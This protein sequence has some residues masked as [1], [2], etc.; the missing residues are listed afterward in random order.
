MLPRLLSFVTRAMAVAQLP[1]LHTL[2]TKL[3]APPWEVPV[4]CFPP[5]V[6]SR[7]LTD[8]CRV[9]FASGAT[10]LGDDPFLEHSPDI[11][12]HAPVCP[13]VAEAEAMDSVEEVLDTHAPVL[14]PPPRFERFSWPREEWEMDEEVSLFDFS[15]ELQGWF[16]SGY[17]D[18]SVDPPSLP[19]SPILRDNLDDS[20][21]ANVCSSREDSNTTSEDVVAA[22]TVMDTLPVGMGSGCDVMMDSSSPEAHVPFS[23]SSVA[24]ISKSL[25]GPASRRSP[26]FVPRWRLTREGPFLP[27]RSPSSIRCLGAGCAFRNTTYLPSFGLC[28]AVWRVWY[29]TAPSPFPGVD[30]CTGIG[31]PVGNGPRKMAAFVVSGSG[32]GCG[33]PAPSGCM[34]DGLKFRFL[35]QYALSLQGT[36]SKILHLGLDYRGRAG[37]GC[38]GTLGT[39]L[40]GSDGGAPPWIRL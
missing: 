22:L 21:A 38:P 23:E 31:E 33:Y 28:A 37:C 27:E 7:G 13:D 17:K 6:S 3:G 35:D 40:F 16:P 29:S 36:A 4:E 1:N 26:V 10:V 39:P 5:S 25:T 34:F 30:R 20:V 12:I 2:I 18:Q 14:R 15:N 9:S 11:L 32:Y 8:P 19:I 24:D